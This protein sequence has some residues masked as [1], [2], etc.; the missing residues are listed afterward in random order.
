MA[1]YGIDCTKMTNDLNEIFVKTAPGKRE[2]V[3]V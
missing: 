2:K 3:K 1:S